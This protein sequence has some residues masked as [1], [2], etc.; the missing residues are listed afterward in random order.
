[1]HYQK[2]LTTSKKNI[3]NHHLKILYYY[4]HYLGVHAHLPCRFK[5]KRPIHFYNTLNV[6]FFFRHPVFLL[7]IFYHETAVLVVPLRIHVLFNLKNVLNHREELRLFS[8]FLPWQT[9]TDILSH[10]YSQSYLPKKKKKI[11]KRVKK[12]T[13]M[14]FLTQSHIVF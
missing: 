2:I 10:V 1:M 4:Y 13:W 9:H 7:Y 8:R 14:T 11:K 6:F 3:V 12:Y 5:H